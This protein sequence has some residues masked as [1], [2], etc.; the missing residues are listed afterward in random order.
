MRSSWLDPATWADA[1]RMSAD[2]LS[3]IPNRLVAQSPQLRTTTSE[4]VVILLLASAA[5]VPRVFMAYRIP[6]ICTD[7]SLYVS[8][9]ESREKGEIRNGAPHFNGLYTRVLAALHTAG[10]SW[11]TAGRVWGVGCGTL[12]VL[13][14]YG[15]VRR[16][17]NRRTAAVACIAYAAQAKLIEWSPELI[18][19]QTFWLLFT[20]AIYLMWRATTEVRVLFHCGAVLAILSATLTRFEG[21]FL[22]IPYVWWGVV[23]MVRVRE[24]RFRLALGLSM[25]VL[26]PTAGLLWTGK[27]ER[28]LQVAT[29]VF[30][31]DP[32]ERVV[33]WWSGVPKAGAAPSTDV[34]TTSAS[35]ISTPLVRKYVLNVF[36]SLTVVTAVF[37]LIG[38]LYYPQLLY[39]SDHAP[40]L[41]VCLAIMAGIWIHLWYSGGEVSSRYGLSVAILAARAAA[42]GLMRSAD[43]LARRVA[44]FRPVL[45]V[46][47][48]LVPPTLLIVAGCVEALS[49]R[50]ESRI[51]KAEVG[52]W[53]RQNYGDGSR[54]A[55]CDEQLPIVGF[56]AKASPTTLRTEQGVTDL[57]RQIREAHPD[58]VLL[59]ALPFSDEAR[60][61]ML[62]ET[63]AMGLQRASPELTVALRPDT[64]VLSRDTRRR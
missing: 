37:V 54:L 34:A 48:A 6:T 36:R 33:A 53:I 39:R 58:V 56:Y 25:L 14:L 19:D 17:F 4:W 2:E 13:P 21:A 27:I 26:L 62:D 61:R 35:R 29:A 49:T 23:R 52:R 57:I 9:A 18:R 5:L 59:S 20:L 8:L 10:M 1:F 42:V 38:I 3:A 43:D 40:V 41:I 63:A 47:A 51:A 15:W 24:Q 12:V 46:R 16:Q 7:G 28:A 45:C 64:I 31:V 22:V 60:R 30:Y 50:Y 44:H 11:E 55:G 32:W